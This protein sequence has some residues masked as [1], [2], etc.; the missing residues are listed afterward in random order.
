MSVFINLGLKKDSVFSPMDGLQ[1]QVGTMEMKR[2]VV[3]YADFI[4][5]QAGTLILERGAELNVNGRG[6]TTG[7]PTAA[8]GTGFNGGSY[9]SEGGVGNSGS[10]T[11][12]GETYGTLYAP[13]LSGASGG[14]GSKGG[15][16]IKINANLVSMYGLLRANG[17]DSTIG[18]A[19]SG[20]SIYIV[21]YDT[22][23]GLGTIEANGGSVTNVNHGA[24]SGGRIAAEAKIDLFST[25]GQFS[26]S[27]GTSPATHGNG[28]PGS[29]Y[30]KMGDNSVIET[31]IIDNANGQTDFYTNLDET[32]T[33]L[34]FD[35]VQIQ[36]YA[37]L[38]I[39]QD[40]QQ[41]TININK[42]IGDG[43]GLLRLRS[44]QTGTLE[45]YSSTVLNSKLE[46]NLE[47]HN[48]GE[49][50]L[51]ETTTIMGKASTALDLNGIMRGVV[52]LILGS[53]R[54]MR[55]G[56]S[57]SIVPF[58]ATALSVQ[59]RVTFGLL[60]L[61]PGST[62]DFDADTGADMLVGTMHAQFGATI[63]ADYFNISCSVMMVELEAKVSAASTDR[64]TS[65][66]IDIY[67]GQ[68]C[69]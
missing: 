61:S 25:E 64:Q 12:V 65:E 28:G 68:V 53:S 27:G 7:V 38:Q 55:M 22:L 20:G 41:R 11:S 19:G 44:N 46:I 59:A 57:A 23:K 31:L 29:V 39:I 8:H 3:L 60:Q 16:Y 56:S 47:L 63:T 49:F 2:Y 24:G 17:N 52:N 4:E 69:I 62:L 15:G 34:Q 30:T 5:I 40:G 51:S 50:L 9:A 10:I 67:T 58:S 66:L 1:L 6:R 37:K 36:N 54:H 42:V 48:G 35:V 33:D 45:R 32:R 13:V 14:S 43:T 18:G 21:C 26:A